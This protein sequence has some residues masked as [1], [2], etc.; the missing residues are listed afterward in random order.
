M[1]IDVTDIA[2]KDAVF[3]IVNIFEIN[4]ENAKFYIP[5]CHAFFIHQ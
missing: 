5:K 4:R 2:T 1:E 3:T